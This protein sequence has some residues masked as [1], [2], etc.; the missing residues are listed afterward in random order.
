M[1]QTEVSNIGR[2]AGLLAHVM[3]LVEHG[4]GWALMV[5]L[6]AFSISFSV[7]WIVTE[8]AEN[9]DVAES[10]LIAQL[11][12]GYDMDW[13]VNFMGKKI[14]PQKVI[15]VVEN[16][17]QFQ[18]QLNHAKVTAVAA[19]GVGL[20]LGAI[21]GIF[22]LLCFYLVG[23]FMQEEEF[24]RGATILPDVLTYNE[25]LMRNNRYVVK[26]ERGWL[27]YLKSFK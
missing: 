12:D 3:H 9:R 6:L 23:Q 7:I 8:S 22:A 13:S 1:S 15:R 26:I 16:F 24:V 4:I 17:P 11:Y 19:A 20:I 5:G 25:L 2:G 27:R 10:Y 21:A 18:D 14:S